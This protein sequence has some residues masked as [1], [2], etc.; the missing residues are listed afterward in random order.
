MLQGCQGE[1]QHQAVDEQIPRQGDEP[2]LGKKYKIQMGSK[3]LYSFTLRFMV[4]SPFSARGFLRPAQPPAAPPAQQDGGGG[5]YPWRWP[6]AREDRYPNPARPPPGAA[7]PEGA[8]RRGRRRR[9][10]TRHSSRS[11]PRAARKG[12]QNS[13]RIQPISPSLPSPEDTPPPRC[14]AGRRGPARGRGRESTFLR[15]SAGTGRIPL[16]KGAQAVPLSQG[17]PYGEAAKGQEIDPRQHHGESPAIPPSRAG[18]RVQTSRAG[19]RKR[20][21]ALPLRQTGP[22][23]KRQTRAGMAR[24]ASQHTSATITPRASPPPQG[25]AGQIARQGGS[26]GDGE[27]VGVG[28]VGHQPCQQGEAKQEPRTHHGIG[29]RSPAAS[30][31]TGR[32]RRCRRATGGRGR[33]GRRAPARRRRPHSRSTKGRSR[34][35]RAA[36]GT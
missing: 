31:G 26:K 16:E 9:L 15:R 33:A 10:V 20:R 36:K 24:I 25:R 8:S 34:H 7:S 23:A 21:V 17:H 30:P 18:R 29:G 6:F 35:S 2:H 11:N 13:T 1:Q 28:H 3:T 14:P 12:P 5:H 32:N 22:G 27:H 19:G 4:F